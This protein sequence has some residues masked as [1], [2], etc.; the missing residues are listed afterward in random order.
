MPCGAILYFD[1]ETDAAIRG[2]WQVIEDAGQM[3][4]MPGLNYPPHMTLVVCDN[5]HFDQVREQLKRFVAEHPPMPVQFNGL[6]VFNS[7]QAIVH[8]AITADRPLLDVHAAFD[9]LARP[10][11]TGERDF[12]RPGLWVPHVTLNQGFDRKDTG[13]VIDALQRATLP[14]RG[15]LREIVLVD[16]AP[17]RS[18]LTEMFTARLGQYL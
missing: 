1:D 2:L 14:Q 8:L 7:Q 10:H 13:M 16:F 15:L 12:S 18:G 17:E 11:M 4:N 3:Y 6:G 5:M 9:E